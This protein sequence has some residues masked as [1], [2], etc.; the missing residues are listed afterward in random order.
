MAAEPTPMALLRSTSLGEEEET[1][2]VSDDVI[3]D[4]DRMNTAKI[5]E[6]MYQTAIT[7]AVALILLSMAYAYRPPVSLV[8]GLAYLAI[9]AFYLANILYL[10]CRAP[11]IYRVYSIYEIPTKWVSM[12][13]ASENRE[14]RQQPILSISEF[15]AI[16]GGAAHL[17]LA[18][19]G[20]YAFA[21]IMTF[22]CT[23]FSRTEFQCPLS[24]FLECVG[25]FGVVVLGTFY[26][27]P[28]STGMRN[29][30]NTGLGLSCCTLLG[31]LL[32]RIDENEH[33]W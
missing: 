19:L 29:G 32:Q 15:S 14:Y 16:A 1:I 13:V 20:S 11:Q 26:L 4:L 30:H 23:E 31:F 10:L 7:F 3:L 2:Q 24:L 33:I 8:V 27:D 28:Y 12:P 17:L 22:V 21:I 5:R 6:G 18:R 25:A 9:F